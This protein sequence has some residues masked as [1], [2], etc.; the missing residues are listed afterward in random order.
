MDAIY[1]DP[2]YTGTMNNYFG[3]MDLSMTFAKK[4]SPWN[5]F[6]K[7]LLCLLI[8]LVAF[9]FI[10]GLSFTLFYSFQRWLV[11][12]FPLFRDLI[13]LGIPY[14]SGSGRGKITPGFF[15]WGQKVYV[16]SNL[17]FGL[18]WFPHFGS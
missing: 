17:E 18:P 10:L 5:T 12:F 11:G 4:L 16:A 6:C 1:L 3:F 13:F 2:P 8:L 9:H 15:F 7:K 14:P